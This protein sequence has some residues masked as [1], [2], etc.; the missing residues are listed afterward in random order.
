[1][2]MR[3]SVSFRVILESEHFLWSPSSGTAEDIDWD[4]AFDVLYGEIKGHFCCLRDVDDEYIELEGED[5]R[6]VGDGDELGRLYD[7]AESEEIVVRVMVEEMD[8]VEAA[9]ISAVFC[10]FLICSD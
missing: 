3:K 2:A 4:T 10:C 8:N 9:T 6:V 5:E 1:M 7:G